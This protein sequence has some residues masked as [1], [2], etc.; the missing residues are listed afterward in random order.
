[1][2]KLLIV[3]IAIMTVLPAT[4]SP[5]E[6]RK[7][8]GGYSYIYHP[9]N[10]S[11]YQ[12][13][14]CSACG[15][16]EE[17]E[18]SDK[19]RVDCL[20]EKYAI[21]YDFANKKYEAVGQA[22]HYGIMTGRTPKVVLILDKKYEKRQL[23]YYERIKRIGEAY[24]FEVEYITDDILNLDKDGHCPYVDCKCNRQ[25]LSNKGKCNSN[26]KNNK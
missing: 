16:V 11:S 5:F 23:R 18:L 1:M 3:I 15:G 12:H 2:K 10:E 24:G 8:K 13:A 26:R 20:T 17:Y 19:T 4:A 6:Y 21:E 22:L 9:H 25:H 7:T 14:H